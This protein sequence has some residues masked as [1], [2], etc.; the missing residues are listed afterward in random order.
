M[1]GRKGCENRKWV[2]GCTVKMINDDEK[3]GTCMHDDN[4]HPGVIF[5]NSTRPKS[6]YSPPLEWT[7]NR[8]AS[9]DLRRFRLGVA[10]FIDG[11]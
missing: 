9:E 7:R 2:P 10:R 4:L 3:R 8:W 6:R 1:N 11:H 5:D